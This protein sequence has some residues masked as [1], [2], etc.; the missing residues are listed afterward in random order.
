M[1]TAEIERLGQNAAAA[2][3]HWERC[4]AAEKEATEARGKVFDAWMSAR[5]QLDKAVQAFVLSKLS[6]NDGSKQP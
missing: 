2:M 4:A 6:S 1:N 3:S 5:D